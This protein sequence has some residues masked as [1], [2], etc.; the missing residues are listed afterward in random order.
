MREQLTNA[1]LAARLKTSGR[2]E[3]EST[4]R[5]NGVRATRP[6]SP[7]VRSPSARPA[8]TAALEGKIETLQAEIAKLE[9]VVAGQRADLERERHRANA[10]GDE[11]LKAT[12][13]LPP[14]CRSTAALEGDR[15][16]ERRWRAWC[17][18]PSP[19]SV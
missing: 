18:A 17:A 2:R 14:W 8:A 7:S 11:L 13:T 3:G 16:G 6:C 1:N 5:G 19:T 10:L 4:L 15:G 9:A 12:L